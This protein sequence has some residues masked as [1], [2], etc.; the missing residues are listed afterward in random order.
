MLEHIVEPQAALPPLLR[1]RIDFRIHDDHRLHE[2]WRVFDF[3]D[4]SLLLERL[5]D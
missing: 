2:P 5:R 3:A 1:L 4:K